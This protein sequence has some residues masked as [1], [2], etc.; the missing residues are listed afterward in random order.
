M[1]AGVPVPRREA[2]LPAVTAHAKRPATRGERF[3]A[4]PLA[5]ER[6]QSG[7]SRRTRNAEYAQAYRGFESLPLRH[8]VH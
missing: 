4:S 1:F 5:L 3:S 8:V 7:R 6:W 2:V